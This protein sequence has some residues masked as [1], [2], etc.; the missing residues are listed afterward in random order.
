MEDALKPFAVE[1][2]ACVAAEAHEQGG[3]EVVGGERREQRPQ[4]HRLVPSLVRESKGWSHDDGF[5]GQLDPGRSVGIDRPALL[6]F[7]PGE[8]LAHVLAP[9]EAPHA[10][11]LG[12]WVSVGS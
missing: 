8:P 9:D 1:D 11:R 5:V 3:D 4:V 7:E 6:A 12:L 2:S 10:R